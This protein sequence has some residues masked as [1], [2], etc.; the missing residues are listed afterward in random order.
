MTEKKINKKQFFTQVEK[1]FYNK[2]VYYYVRI[3]LRKFQKDCLK[4]VAEDKFLSN[5]LFF[6]LY[7]DPSIRNLLSLQTLNP[8]I[9]LNFKKQYKAAGS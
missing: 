1:I 3:K 5:S 7:F 8:H 4:T 2:N 6:N 9:F